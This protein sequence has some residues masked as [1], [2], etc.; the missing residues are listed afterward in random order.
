MY[1]ICY[2]SKDWLRPK[3]V[4]MLLIQHHFCRVNDSKSY[5]AKSSNMIFRT[6]YAVLYKQ[7]T[8]HGVEFFKGH[9]RSKY[10]NEV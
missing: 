7:G 8:T 10:L 9:K 4:K 1:G 3:S 2:A 5:M 6:L